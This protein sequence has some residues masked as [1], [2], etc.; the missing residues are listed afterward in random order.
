MLSFNWVHAQQGGG[1]AVA[2]DADDIGGVV[3]SAK[4]PEAG[5]WVIAETTDL[6]TKFAKI[7][8][9]DGNGRYVIPDLPRERF[10]VWVRG[11]G[12]GDSAKVPA[13]PFSAL[14]SK[15]PVDLWSW[16]DGQ[17]K[18]GNELLAISHNANVSDGRMY[19]TEVDTKGRPIDA[20]Y[21]AS[22]VRNEPPEIRSAIFQAWTS[23]EAQRA[24]AARLAAVGKR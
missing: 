11:Y 4:G 13:Q 19:P 5:V 8:V 1:A 10:N 15:H 12:M 22:R 6:P 21:A 9:T 23:E 24:F 14:D 7:V 16:M 3:T 17:R 2:I 20:A 18:A